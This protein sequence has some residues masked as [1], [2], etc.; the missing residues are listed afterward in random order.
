MVR[1]DDPTMS[2]NTT[3][4][5][6]RSTW[7]AGGEPVMNAMTRSQSRAQSALV[8]KKWSA[9]CS[10][11]KVAPGIA[12]AMARPTATGTTASPTP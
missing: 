4:A 8:S 5:K 9:V 10:S 1:A 11:T 12:A 6:R 2:V 3:V 7:L